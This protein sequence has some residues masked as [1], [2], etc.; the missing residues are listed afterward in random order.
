MSTFGIASLVGLIF[1][2][3]GCWIGAFF[4]RETNEIIRHQCKRVPKAD[5]LIRDIFD[6]SH[7]RC[8]KC[9]EW[10]ELGFFDEMEEYLFNE[11]SY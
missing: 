10:Y 6:A 2:A 4:Q 7:K 1:F 3:I 9:G 8:E 5:K 11:E